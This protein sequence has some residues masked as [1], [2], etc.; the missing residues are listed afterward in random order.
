LLATERP[1]YTL[2]PRDCRMIKRTAQ[3]YGIRFEFRPPDAP[4]Y[5]GHIERLIG[6]T[7]GARSNDEQQNDISGFHAKSHY[8]R[9]W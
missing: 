8:E 7:M 2:A 6:T 4:R 3:E 5:G 9:G 1:I